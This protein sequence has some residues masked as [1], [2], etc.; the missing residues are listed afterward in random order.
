LDLTI[1][2]SSTSNSSETACNS[3]TWS[4]NGITYTASGIYTCT[5]QNTVGCT[6][7][8]TLNLTINTSTT[9]NTSITACNS[10]TWSASGLVYSTSG[11]YT[12]TSLNAAG[13][14]HTSNLALTVVN[15]TSSQSVTACSSYFWPIAGSNYYATGTYTRTYL[16]LGCVVTATLNLTIN[17]PTANTTSVGSC[18]TYTWACNGNTY[19]ASGLY[20]CTSLNAAGCVHTETLNLL[21]KTTTTAAPQNV[22]A[23]NSYMWSANGIT[24]TASGTY[25][26][27][28]LNS[29]GCTHTQ[30]L[31]LV[32][33]NSST[34]TAQPVT[35]CVSYTWACTGLTYTTSGIKTCTSINAA[36]CVHTE[37]LNLT[38]NPATTAPTV[39][40]VVCNSYTWSC[41]GNTYTASG[42]YTCTSL[43]A[44]GCTQTQSLN[45]TIKG[46]STSSV[47]AATA[48]NSYTWWNTN[49]TTS[50]V[51]VYT[52]LN[53]AG[54][55]NTI[56]M[57]LTINNSTTSN[58]TITACNS[59]T[60]AASGLT[61]T[62]SGTYTK[63]STNASGC[64]HTSKLVLTIN[65]STSGTTAA[66]ACNSYTWSCNGNTY[67]S[68][69]V[70]ICTSIN[71]QGCVH[72]QTLQL[73]INQS[74][75][76]TANVTA[77][78][79]YTW[80]ASGLSYT[81]SGTYTKTSLNVTGCLHT[82]TLNLVINSSTSS[83][84]TATACN[85]YFWTVSGLTYTSSGTY[86]STALNSAGCVH[87]ST[88]VLTINNSTSNTSV[89]S[90]CNSYTWSCNGATYST[91]G[92]YTC[93][94][95][96]SQG[97][98]H[99]EILSL[100]IA[101]NTTGATNASACNSYTWSCNGMTYTT[102]GSYTCT[103][104][105]S[106]GCLN[107]QT[108][109]LTIT[110]STST[111]SNITACNSYAWSATGS[112]YYASGTYTKTTLVAGC[113]NTAI[114]NLTINLPSANTTVTSGCN[115]FTWS[116]NGV[117]YTTGGIYTA[118]YLNAGGCVHTQTLSLVINQSTT[119]TLPS[120]TACNSYNWVVNGVG[121]LYTS[122]GTYTRTYLNQG[123]TQTLIRTITIN[124]STS[125]SVA[126]TACNSYTWTLSGVTY[127]TTG[128][129]TKTTNNA[130]GCTHTTTLNLTINNTTTSSVAVT[131]CNSYTWALSG[132]TYTASGTYTKTSVN[133]AGCTH[134]TTLSLTINA[135]TS[136][137]T[138]ASACISY[139]WSVNS[140]TYTS[141]G[142]YTSTSLNAAGC[143]HTETLNL[144]ISTTTTTSTVSQCCSY[145][146]SVSGLTYTTSGTYTMTSIN[147]AGCL[148]TS[149]LILTITAAP[150]ITG[151]NITA[152]TNTSAT[153]N[154]TPV[155]GVSSYEIG[156]KPST[157][158]TWTTVIVTPTLNVPM[159]SSRVI[160]GL[161]LG[162]TYQVE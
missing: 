97:C 117:T 138:S 121:V 27:T 95:I 155:A 13:C 35:A 29:Q 69:G 75:T 34:S 122:T 28:S 66:S 123:C 52:N 71:S 59:Y 131:A 9:S 11:S 44:N 2:N 55:P 157:S 151:I 24:Y 48:C 128:V 61:Y 132:L 92:S 53:T 77:C 45:L 56:T 130:V 120:V 36:G 79:S 137:S 41:N 126:V 15:T 153:V 143:L 33:N 135:N 102:S 136:A 110:N 68:S 160:T 80:S 8:A 118:T 150:V 161:T 22:T 149:N 112:T 109:N 140:L 114:L 31:N 60:W 3:Y 26:K 67:T 82:A 85:S 159:P 89:A 108:L 119:A 18:V 7:T 1:N 127:T 115:S 133:A 156:Y 106:N 93:T 96:N 134:T 98:T 144:V 30:T 17:Q 65:N 4:C 99:T 78:N 20:T 146:W 49:Y 116:V 86:T 162:V 148:I 25:T 124:N 37:S 158:S 63:T 40:A 141:S 76:S 94:S 64:V 152:I 58:D 6:N 73:I 104:L 46:V 105:N 154:W 113:V 47:V 91:T 103:S 32:I 19:T 100:T 74:T 125:S 145:T 90:A 107:T 70:Y 111:T 16:S 139:T 5:S 39:S 21:I 14:L 84:D 57:N 101:P 43:N 142:T 147:S 50:G 10:Y 38:I 129:Y 87:T 51:Y 12:Q 81:A 42:I 88:L 83:S 54:C 62:S 23:C 72:T